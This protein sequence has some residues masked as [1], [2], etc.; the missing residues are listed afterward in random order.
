[1]FMVFC[2]LVPSSLRTLSASSSTIS[3]LHPL[4]LQASH[5]SAGDVSESNFMVG[6]KFTVDIF[7]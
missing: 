5:H 6:G 3:G 1:M 2:S 4:L 7:P